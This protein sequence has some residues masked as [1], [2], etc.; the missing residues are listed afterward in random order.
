[1]SPTRMT[2]LVGWDGHMYFFFFSKKTFSSYISKD[3]DLLH[4][5]KK[6]NR[7]CDKS[8]CVMAL[9]SKYMS[10]PYHFK[11]IICHFQ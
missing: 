3:D 6:E 1:M 7:S 5:K 11:M 2:H 9:D 4:K 8:S 10:R